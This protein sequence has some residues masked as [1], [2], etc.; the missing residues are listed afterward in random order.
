MDH[1]MFEFGRILGLKGQRGSL[2]GS[3]I[4]LWLCCRI[5]KG[6]GNVW[7]IGLFAGWEFSQMHRFSLG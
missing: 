3:R 6:Q 1:R 7:R 2:V 4:R 5:V